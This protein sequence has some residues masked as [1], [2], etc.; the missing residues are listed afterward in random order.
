MILVDTSIWIDHFKNS[1]QLLQ[2]LLYEEKVNIHPFIIGEI[3]CGNLS[4]RNDI[5]SLLHSL[6][7]TKVFTNLEIF[8]FIEDNNLFGIGLGLIDIHLLGSAL[9]SS[10]NIWTN[11]KRLKKVAIQYNCCFKV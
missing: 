3:A 1:N 2:Q 5:L 6:P 7:K 10:A 8:K 9:K 11:D 4:N